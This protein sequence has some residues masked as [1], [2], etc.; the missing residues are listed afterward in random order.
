MKFL[1]ITALLSFFSSFAYAETIAQVKKDAK[2]KDIV[3]ITGK[4]TQQTKK[5]K[6]ILTDETGEIK[7][8]IKDYIWQ[9]INVTKPEFDKTYIFTVKVEK[10]MLEKDEFEVTRI[11][12]VK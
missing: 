11:A 3:T 8:K 10:E 2:H 6:Y 9:Q 5:N 12:I 7:I 1:Y 4:L